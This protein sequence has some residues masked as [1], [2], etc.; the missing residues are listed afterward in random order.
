MMARPIH[1]KHKIQFYYLT[2]LLISIFYDYNLK[3]GTMG[4]SQG[5]VSQVEGF[6]SFTYKY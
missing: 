2:N 3:S 6:H 1:S 4:H 5:K